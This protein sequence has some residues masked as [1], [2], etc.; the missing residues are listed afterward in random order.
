MKQAK[1]KNKLF[2]WG[3]WVLAVALVL[4]ATY[5]VVLPRIFPKKYEAYV[6]QYAAEYQLDPHLVYAVI[7]AESRSDEH[8]VS[9][10]NAM[11]LMQITDGTGAWG[12]QMLEMEGYQTEDL[13]EPETNIRIGCWYLRE[14]I[15][16]FGLEET[17]LAAYN[18]GSGNVSEW[19]QN[20]AYSSDG[21]TL[22]EIP[23]GQTKRYVKKVMMV[24]KIYGFVYP[25]SSQSEKES[26]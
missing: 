13:F 3:N 17:A 4:L 16:Q 7:F 24:Q 12:A 1:T 2:R 19:L 10:K 14:L 6:T 26:T 5:Y 20:P 11:G 21:V 8:A 25:S 9:H 22:T 15:N 18:A 23:F